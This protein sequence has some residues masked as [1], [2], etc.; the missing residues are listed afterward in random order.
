MPAA[1]IF[2]IWAGL[3]VEIFI[4]VVNILTDLK[5]DRVS[6][7]TRLEYLTIM[8]YPLFL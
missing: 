5:Y 8:I 7:K 6:I 3:W 2:T 1:G 4:G